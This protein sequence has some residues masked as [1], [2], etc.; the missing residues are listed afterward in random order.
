MSFLHFVGAI[1]D[2]RVFI[3]YFLENAIPLSIQVRFSTNLKL[4]MG[5]IL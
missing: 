3:M 5:F 4:N 2:F 1:L